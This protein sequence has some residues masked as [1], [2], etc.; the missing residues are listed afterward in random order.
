MPL[1]ITLFRTLL[2]VLSKPS[3]KQKTK[4]SEHKYTYIDSGTQVALF[5]RL[6]SPV[7]F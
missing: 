7:R 4:E 5:N 1:F 2:Q 3:R 6:Q